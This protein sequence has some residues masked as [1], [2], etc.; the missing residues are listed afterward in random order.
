MG[1][2]GSRCAVGVD[3]EDD[4]LADGESFTINNGSAD[5]YARVRAWQTLPVVQND[6]ILSHLEIPWRMGAG[7]ARQRFLG[8]LRYHTKRAVFATQIRDMVRRT[9]D[10]SQAAGAGQITI[11]HVHFVTTTVGGTGAGC[12]P[13]AALDTI[14][15]IHEE[16]PSVHVYATAHLLVP[17]A[18]M[19]SAVKKNGKC[20]VPQTD[21]SRN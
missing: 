11:C 15:A 18:L 3:G 9:M 19:A 6:C 8:H 12:L 13:I 4:M 20:S 2:A 21:C 10:N 5:D 17:S 7:A 16:L 14:A 1:C